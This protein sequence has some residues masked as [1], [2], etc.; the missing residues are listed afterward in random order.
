MTTTASGSPGTTH[1]HRT[2][3]QCVDPWPW[4]AALGFASGTLV[5]TPART[6]Y[7][8]GQ[9]ALDDA[10]VVVAPGDMA[11][12]LART[13]DNVETVLLVAGMTLS[14]VVRYDVYTTDMATYFSAAGELV[15]RFAA[16]GVVPCGGIAAQVGALAMP[17]L[18]VEV[19]RTAAR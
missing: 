12:Q 8:A 7:L 9:A 11:G 2:R 6:L 16:A 17:G 14:D 4:T 1:E 10:G 18:M 5:P 15:G 13:M 19:V 3:N